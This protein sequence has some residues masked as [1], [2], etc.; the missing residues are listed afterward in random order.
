M[1]KLID[2]WILMGFLVGNDFVPH[3]PNLMINN[4]ALPLL[5]DTYKSVLPKLDGK[6]TFTFK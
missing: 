5:Y 1:E 3:L 4:N 2:D 6:L